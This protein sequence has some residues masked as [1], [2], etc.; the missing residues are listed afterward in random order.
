MA[1]AP[2]AAGHAVLEGACREE[3]AAG[4][5]ARTESGTH[6]EGGERRPGNG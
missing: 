3:K 6:Q 2:V 1:A 5:S 4:G